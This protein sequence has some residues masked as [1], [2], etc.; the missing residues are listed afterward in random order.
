MLENAK[1]LVTL[2]HNSL[3]EPII[4]VNGTVIQ[5]TSKREFK[6]ILTRKEITKI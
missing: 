6:R 4:L 3:S 2:N 1:I 5:L